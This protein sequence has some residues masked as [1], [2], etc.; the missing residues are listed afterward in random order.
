M[1]LFSYKAIS[2]DGKKIAGVIDADSLSLAKEKLRK[3]AVFVTKLYQTERSKKELQL[4]SGALLSFTRELSQLLSAG[5]PL[6]ESLV[7][8]EE[9]YKKAKF[10]S[11]LLDLCDRLR[12]GQYLSAALSQYPKS[13]DPVYLSM[14]RGGEKS[15]SLSYVF[16]ELYQL[17]QRRQK[18]KKQLIAAVAYPAFLASFSFLMVMGLLLFVIPS[19]QELFVGRNLHPLTRGVLALSSFL[20]KGFLPMTA[21]VCLGLTALIYFLRGGKGKALLHSIFIKIP[22]LRTPLLQAALIRFCRST[23]VLLSGGVP[24]VEALSTARSTL[25]F[26][27]FERV[28]QEAER[29]IA[30]GRPLSQ[31]LRSHSIVPPLLARMVAIA[32]ETGKLPEMLRSTSDIYDDEL[33]RGLAHLTTFLQPALLV[34]LGGIVGLVILSILLPLTD[35]SSLI[36]A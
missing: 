13:F 19:M 17:I 4:R 15:G 7:T 30:E 27:T 29:R 2:V 3:S 32:E 11:L 35:T 28:I 24:L 26:P 5:L 25:H 23:S 20:Q 36:A 34:I 6:H 14:V 8:I 33:E 16:E 1:P 9:K 31:T 10:H 22:F 18:L 12:G 21:T